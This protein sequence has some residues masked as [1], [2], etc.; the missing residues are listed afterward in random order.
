MEKET[1]EPIN[2]EELTKKLIEAEEQN[3]K[4]FIEAYNALCEKHKLQIMPSLGVELRKVN[5]SST[6]N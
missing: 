4:E 1:K 6:N 2:T 3:K 5:P